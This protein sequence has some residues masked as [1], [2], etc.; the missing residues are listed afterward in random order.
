[1]RSI[2]TPCSDIPGRR[3][4]GGM[5]VGGMAVGGMAVGEMAAVGQGMVAACASGSN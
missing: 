4:G 2:V 5:A 1:M 3:T